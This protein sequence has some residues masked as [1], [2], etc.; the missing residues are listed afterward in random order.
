MSPLRIACL[1]QDAPPRRHFVSR[2]H[3]AVP[4]DLLIVERGGTTTA[5]TSRPRHMSPSDVA[6]AVRNRLRHR[7][8]S[9]RRR[10]DWQHWF[11]DRWRAFPTEIPRMD[12]PS[13]NDPSVVARL[14]A[15]HID[16]VVDHGTTIVR[17]AVLSAVRTAYNL[18]WGL[19]P[20]YRGTACTEWALLNWDPFTI[21]VTIHRLTRQI[22]GGGIV[23]Q[24]RAVISS[25]DTPHRIDMQLTALGTELTVRILQR[26]SRGETLVEYPQDFTKGFLTLN[27]QWSRPL[28]RQIDHL[29]AKGLI[30]QMLKTPARRGLVPIVELDSS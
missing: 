6:D 13:I 20:Y 8:D 23:A 10:D 9:A 16:V 7:L 1:V 2:I 12:V 18:H 29:L 3:E 11:G 5:P 28:A 17:D 30:G 15:D 19:S 26:L 4:V 14:A 25:D 27:R 24:A 21:G 22:D